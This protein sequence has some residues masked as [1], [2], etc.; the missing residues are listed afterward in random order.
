[1]QIPDQRIGQRRGRGHCGFGE[2]HW[3]L[4]QMGFLGWVLEGGYR[5]ERLPPRHAALCLV[6]LKCKDVHNVN[7]TL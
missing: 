4:K 5:F 3:A 2:S 7:L 1:M 6:L